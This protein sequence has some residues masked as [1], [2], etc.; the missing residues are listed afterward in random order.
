MIVLSKAALNDGMNSFVFIFYRQ[1]AGTIAFVPVLIFRNITVG[2]EFYGVGLDYTTPSLAAAINNSKQA[3]TFFLAVLLGYEKLKLRTVAGAAK[4]G[5]IMLCLGGVATLAFYEGPH[6]RPPFR[7]HRHHHHNVKGQHHSIPEH[8]IKGCFLMFTA[9]FCWSIWYVFQAHVLK[10]LSSKLMF[11]S[12]QCLLSAVQTGAVAVVVDRD[13]S[14]WRMGWDIRLVSVVCSGFMYSVIGTNIQ[15]W[16]IE[17]KGPVFTAMW[18]PLCLIITIF[19]ST[20]LLGEV[21][22]LGR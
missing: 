12:L 8:W 3:M 10:E 15:S 20:F 6:F 14:H 4:L 7:L 16:L 17:K 18:T 9:N 2:F 21:L 22:S 13:L 1:L 11:T 19:F 5:G